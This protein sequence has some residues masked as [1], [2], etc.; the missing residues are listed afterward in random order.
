MISSLQSKLLT[1]RALFQRLQSSKKRSKLQ[2]GFTL[3]ELLIVVIIIGVLTS[4]ALPAFL[5]QQDK[6]KISASNANALSAARA[7]AAVL[8]SGVAAEITA[9]NT[10]TTA[11]GAA[12]GTCASGADSVFTAVAIDGIATEAVATVFT[13]GSTRL[14]TPAAK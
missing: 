1:Q 4:I 8:V 11:A 7:C 2:A 10:E 3:I 13:N 14:T 12:A 9:F 6:A 5:N